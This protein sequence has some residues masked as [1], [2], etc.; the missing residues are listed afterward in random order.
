M[1]I[2]K[3]IIY[4]EQRD[5]S[6]IAQKIT[7]RIIMTREVI[8]ISYDWILVQDQNNTHKKTKKQVSLIRLK[9]LYLFKI[10]P[11]RSLLKVSV[12]YVVRF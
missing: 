4:P 2:G 11:M 5:C 9:I 3:T 8:Y 1:E 12:K 6:E 7:L 10:F